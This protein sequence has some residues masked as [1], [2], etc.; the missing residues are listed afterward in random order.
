M[1]YCTHFSGQIQIHFTNISTAS[2]RFLILSEDERLFTL[3][4]IM[5]RFPNWGTKRGFKAE[6]KLDA[7]M[8]FYCS[9]ILICNKQFVVYEMVYVGTHE[10][11]YLDVYHD[12]PYYFKTNSKEIKKMHFISQSRWST[13][14]M[15]K[16]QT[17]PHTCSFYNRL[18][19]N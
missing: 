19:L 17:D 14:R 5:P 11:E 12:K 15:R 10:V 8:V 9:D 13:W 7:L 6:V 16:S 1:L 4:C 3:N 2:L 18:N